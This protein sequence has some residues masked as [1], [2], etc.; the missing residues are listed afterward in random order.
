MEVQPGG[1]LSYDLTVPDRDP[2]AQRG[3]VIGLL[4]TVAAWF[5]VVVGGWFVLG[6]VSDPA[7]VHRG[8]PLLMV[9]VAVGATA[10]GARRTLPRPRRNA[11]LIILAV[12]SG[13]ALLAANT[14]T[15][16]KPTIPQVKAQIDDIH[17]PAG[18]TV[19]SETTH[20]DRFCRHGCPRVDRVYTAPADDPDPVKTFVL[21]MFRQGWK[22][23]SDVPQDLATTAQRGVIFVQV[24]ETSPHVVS[25]TATRQS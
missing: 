13:A 18:F 5:V 21:A 12:S 19:V 4:A 25:L 2:S 15:N 24:G 22:N 16:V 10:W 17:L 14:L 9:A 23:P 8:F 11:V 6:F 7:L 3:I 1:P 20:G